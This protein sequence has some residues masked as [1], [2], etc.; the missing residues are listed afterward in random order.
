M[1]ILEIYKIRNLQVAKIST[2]KLGNVDM[3][4]FFYHFYLDAM[5]EW[6]AL[7]RPES[8]RFLFVRSVV[9]ETVRPVAGEVTCRDG[10]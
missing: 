8:G 2:L 5:T 4:S 9:V 6:T 1:F 10:I 7:N 3:D